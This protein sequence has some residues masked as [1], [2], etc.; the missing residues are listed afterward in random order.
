[1]PDFT[2]AQLEKIR[3]EFIRGNPGGKYTD[4]LRAELDGVKAFE[5]YLQDNRRRFEE[6]FAQEKRR[7]LREE[8]KQAEAERQAAEK[9]L[10]VY[11]MSVY[12]DEKGGADITAE[13]WQ[14]REYKEWRD[15]Y[16]LTHSNDTRY[17]EL[18]ERVN[19]FGRAPK[20]KL[21]ELKGQGNAVRD[22][23]LSAVLQGVS[24]HAAAQEAGF[25]VANNTAAE[26]VTD[27]LNIAPAGSTLERKEEVKRETGLQSEAIY[28][29]RSANSDSNEF[30]L[31]KV[32]LQVLLDMGVISQDIYNA[33][34]QTPA[35][36]IDR[37]NGRRKLNDKEQEEF[38]QRLTARMTEDEQLF[39]LLPPAV[40]AAEYEKSYDNL[41]AAMERD[42]QSE[43][44]PK[45]E[46]IEKLEA[47]IDELSADAYNRRNLFFADVTNISDTY[48]GYM[49]MFAARER[50]LG[51]G[52][53][54]N[55]KRRM[56]D[57]NRRNLD[58]LI[59]EYD[60]EWNLQNISAADADRLNRRFDELSQ[61]LEQTGLDDDTLRL[62]SNFKFLD[63]N[64]QAEPQFADAD[65]NQSDVWK[66]SA[67]IIQGGK[68]ENMVRIARHN[69]LLN[70]LG[71]AEELNVEN[72][73]AELNNEL[74]SVLYAAHVADQVEKGI[75][76]NPNQF[77]DKKYRDQFIAE[78]SNIEKPISI[79]PTAYE[80]AVDSQING[81]GAYAHR[82]G[83]KI[84][85][86]KSVVARLFEPLKDLD[87]RAAGRTA[88]TVDKRA[89]RIEMLKRTTKSAASAFLVSGAITV[90]ATATAADA[91]LTAATLGM[92]KYAGMAVGSALA[93]GMTV[94][95]I[96]RWRK[97]RKEAGEKRGL[98]ALVKDRRMMMTI[99]TTALGATALGFAITGNPGVAQAL[100]Y[101]SLALG[102]ANGIIN[103]MQDA[104]K[105]GLGGWE[106]AGWA[107]LQTVAT[108]GAGFAGRWAANQGIDLYNKHNPENDVFQHRAKI[109]EHTETTISAETET[110]YKP[111]V[112]ENAQKILDYWY[113][114]NPDL[115]QQRI[116][117]IEAYNA[118]HGTS[119]NPQ[120]YLL[121]AHDA[122]AL[123]ADNNLLHVQDGADVYSQASH[124]VLGQGW[125]QATGISQE[126][127]NSLADSV[128]VEGINLTPESIRA[129]QEIDGHISA[130]NQVGHVAGGAY[131]N[132][133]VLGFNAETGADGRAVASEN[134][135]RYTTYADHDGVYEQTVTEKIVETKVDD[136]GMVRNETD[137]GLGMFG[138]LGHRVKG[139]RKLKERAG[140]L[141]DRL[142]GRQ[143]AEPVPPSVIP[144]VIKDQKLLPGHTETGID[145]MLDKEYHIVHGI[146]PDRGEQ[147]RYRELVEKEMAVDAMGT[148]NLGAYLQKRMDKFEQTLAVNVSPNDQAQGFA[149]STKGKIHI[150]RT[151]EAMWKTNL[152]ADGQTLTGENI[153]LLHFEK[154]IG[155]GKNNAENAKLKAAEDRRRAPAAPGKAG[156][157]HGG[158]YDVTAV[159]A[160]KKDRN[161]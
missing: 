67:G 123:T 63:A 2:Q 16:A 121:A 131:Q 79:S 154:L 73:N 95:Q 52:E 137:L 40:L 53:E 35:A 151:R 106:A 36:A 159:A 152:T 156:R 138:I 107:A 111:G 60:R 49:Q 84:G 85:K 99:G 64:G 10:E 70:Q 108:V 39:R 74:Q 101:G 1:M 86:D 69:V 22:Q 119:I 89:V 42:P 75:N 11:L 61:A 5:A 139:I 46:Q 148:D 94:R 147:K 20:I 6:K 109:G 145:K 113:N 150:N 126:T 31:D 77:T 78:L 55:A 41:F 80:A 14:S 160:V 54:D 29:Q 92:N 90:A 112:V 103:N 120:R 72:L 134:G 15:K 19:G 25:A 48:D 122:G 118:E 127:V 136:Y 81:A 24:R 43:H 34:I 50:R 129:F 30:M 143:K 102:S 47:R 98:R 17:R 96:R 141:L 68:L 97:E 157:P 66:Q 32:K 117:A 26:T 44:I 124:K 71:S 21:A 114:D 93:V 76:E 104:R 128:N 142:V 62:V 88:E 158:T 13:T 37:L 83:S 18:K 82:L 56:M 59:G 27:N 33:G 91:S 110:V 100:G 9:E 7:R 153:T 28:R 4:P 57:A 116:D 161:R 132:D 58:E 65:G 38:E 105:N 87:K 135:S 8:E 146:A 140:S 23:K 51:Q 3:E 149:D 45:H 115:L 144:V 12:T 125:S 155:I 130:S 133:G